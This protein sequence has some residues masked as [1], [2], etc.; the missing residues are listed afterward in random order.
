MIRDDGLKY[1]L[2]FI[3]L[4][5]VQGLSQFFTV[6]NFGTIGCTLSMIYRKKVFFKYLINHM[7]FYDV[8]E[9][10][11]GALLTRLSIDTMQLQ[12]IIFSLIGSLVTS[13]ATAITGLVYGFYYDWRLTLVIFAFIPFSC[14]T[15]FTRVSMR[16]DNNKEAM[17]C[18][19]AAGSVLSECAVNTK[20][21]YSFNFQK[22]GLEIYMDCLQYIL[23][24]FIKDSLI[25]GVF[26]GIG[27]FS[28]FAS[29]SCNFYCCKCCGIC[30]AF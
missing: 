30:G 16:H 2:I 11:P 7:A 17:L 14:L 6:W 18:N 9:H 27:Q 15:A 12:D 5:V 3:I 1:S 22:K 29:N 4:A 10:A 26:L 23:D 28:I 19:I 20:T 24:N 8:P 25:N 13:C 21:I